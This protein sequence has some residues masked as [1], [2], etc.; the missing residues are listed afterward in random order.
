MTF[1]DFSTLRYANKLNELSNL[2]YNQKFGAK[3]FEELYG[4]GDAYT[5]TTDVNLYLVNFFDHYIKHKSANTF[6]RCNAPNK[7]KVNTIRK[8]SRSYLMT[9]FL[10]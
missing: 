4:T 8:K 7:I 9:Y 2:A 5:F 6:T 1:S 3:D 10:I